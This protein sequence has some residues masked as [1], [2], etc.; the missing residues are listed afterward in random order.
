[1]AEN[2]QISDS[3]NSNSVSENCGNGGNGAR[4]LKIGLV[5]FFLSVAVSVAGGWLWYKS[6]T[7]LVTDDAFISGH[8]HVVSARV[9]GHVN[10]VAIV[11]NQRVEA[12]DL[13][14]ELDA[15]PYRAKVHECEAAL[16][17]A[18]NDVDAERADVAAARAAVGRAQAQ[19]RQS[20]IDLQRAERLFANEVIARERLDQVHTAA[21]VTRQALIQAQQNLQ[22]TLAKLG[23]LGKSGQTARVAQRA[24]ELESAR[25][26]LDYTRI[27]APVAG[28]VTRRSV[29]VGSNIEAGQ[30]LLAL[31]QLNQPWIIANYKESQLTYLDVGQRVE[32][33]VD[34]Y[35]G[36]VFSGRVDSIMAGTGAAFSLLPPENATGNYV[37]VV[38]RIPVKIVIDPI[39]DPEHVLRV[40]MSVEPTVYTGRSFSEILSASH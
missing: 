33:S 37:K 8:V 4:R 21:T 16:A 10:A 40:G 15:A 14:V 26:H 35:P 11:D 24:A 28:Y 6:K 22:R 34:S 1:M 38:Q 27:F 2:N 31:V 30:A 23:Q 5:L 18:R 12:G 7:E 39:S 13:L 3:Q 20:E 32:F 36:R 9:D 19:A 17:L 29:E 25:L